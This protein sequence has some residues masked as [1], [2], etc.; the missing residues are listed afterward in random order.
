L[1][2]LKI[3]LTVAQ[4]SDCDRIA[5]YYEGLISRAKRAEQPEFQP[6]TEDRKGDE[7]EHEQGH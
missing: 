5:E 3:D 2:G 6:R 4:R 1:R 7:H